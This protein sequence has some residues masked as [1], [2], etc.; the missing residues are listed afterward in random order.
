MATVWREPGTHDEIPRLF[1]G[2]SHCYRSRESPL[3]AERFAVDPSLTKLPLVTLYVTDRCNSRCV[4]CDYW[5][6]GRDDMDLREDL[7]GSRGSVAVSAV[8]AVGAAAWHVRFAAEAH[9]A[10]A[11]RACLNVD[12]RAIVKHVTIVTAHTETEGAQ[13]P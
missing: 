4:T 9:A 2:A 6:H 1:A 5:R 11:A 8:S 12:P 13:Q 10:V 3:P 7:L